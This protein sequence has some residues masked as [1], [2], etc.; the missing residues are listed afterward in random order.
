M[1]EISNALTLIAIFAVMPS[2]VVWICLKA[3]NQKYDRQIEFAT[4]VL[5]KDPS[6]NLED[7]FAK[8]SPAKR[9]YAQKSVS[10]VRSSCILLFLGLAAT[11]LAIVFNS[12]DI[13][14]GFVAFGIAA[15]FLLAVGLAF[16]VS[17]LYAQKLV[18]KGLLK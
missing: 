14:E 12:E 1:Y 5:E 17:F 2:L 16:L 6:L 11:A 10:L 9:T 7:F 8:L 4:R 15:C 18:R 13:E 3:R